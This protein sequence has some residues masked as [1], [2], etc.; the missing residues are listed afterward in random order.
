MRTLAQRRV[1]LAIVL[2]LALAIRLAAGVWWQSRL[3]DERSFGFPDSA[4]YWEL[5]QHIARGQ[6]YE[7]GP[8]Q[9]RILRTPGYPLVLAALMRVVGDDPPAMWARALGAVIGTLAV[10]CV[11]YLAWILF[12]DTVALIAAAMAA[13]YPGAIAISTFVLSEAPFCLLM[14]LQLVLWVA[15]WR[16][17]RTSPA[18]ALAV[19]SGLAAGA[20]VMMRPSWLLFTPFAAAIGIAFFPHR[21]R[22]LLLVVVMLAAICAVMAPWWIRNYR[23]AG[24]PVLTTSQVGASLYDGLSP[25]ATGASDMQFVERFRNVQRQ[26]DETAATPPAGLF[27]VRVDRRMLDASIEWTRQNPRRALELALI[28]LG[29]TWNVWPNAEELR[30]VPMRIVVTLGF[31]PLIIL[32]ICG[33]WRHL[34][35]GWPYVLCVLPAVYVSLLHIVFVGS[36]R[37]REPPMMV[38]IV[39][40]AALAAPVVWRRV[41]RERTESPKTSEIDRD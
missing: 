22:H 36:I 11:A 39:L 32:A 21:K 3:G 35:Q 27:E 17:G 25:E 24:R 19:A 5:G 4:T 26:E 23:L 1:P 9:T 40:A 38:L 31:V 7:F 37:Y 33:A 20:A 6:P 14:L 41:S 10:L 29:R 8:H 34:R 28:K 16:Q 30:S 13:L 12:D 15:A 2:A 18:A